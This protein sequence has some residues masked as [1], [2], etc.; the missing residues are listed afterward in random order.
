MGDWQKAILFGTFILVTNIT[1]R[2]SLNRMWVN[3]LHTVPCI[4]WSRFRTRFRQL[5][6][7][8]EPLNVS[9]LCFNELN[10]GI[11]LYVLH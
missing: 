9:V 10:L 4:V 6:K 11:V 2:V 1:R 8:T 5:E 3:P 7:F